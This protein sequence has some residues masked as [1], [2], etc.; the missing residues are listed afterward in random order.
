MMAAG[1]TTAAGTG[2][3]GGQGE[4]HWVV[5]GDGGG[6]DEDDGAADPA[7]ACPDPVAAR[8][9]AVASARIHPAAATGV[10]RRP[11]W[12]QPALLVRRTTG[13]GAGASSG[14]EGVDWSPVVCAGGVNIA[15]ILGV[16][17]TFGGSRRGC[18]G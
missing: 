6:D 12:R 10:L 3:G 13:S 5:V 14:G 2:D 11:S 9:P 4:L 7:A 8:R 16:Q 15:G 1:T 18:Y 17:V